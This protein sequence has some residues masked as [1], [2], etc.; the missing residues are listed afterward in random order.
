MREDL[1][2]IVDALAA[3]LGRG[4]AIDD[5]NLGLLAHSAHIDEVDAVRRQSILGRQVS[6]AAR[7]WALSCGIAEA[8]APV[9][10]PANPAISCAARVCAPIRCRDRLLGFLFVID[11]DESTT[12]E[13]IRRCEESARQA[14]EVIYESRFMRHREWRRERELL[15]N[16]LDEDAEVRERAASALTDEGFFGSEQIVVAVVSAIAD[17]GPPA[18]DRLVLPLAAT[19]DRVRRALPPHSAI[20]AV[21]PRHAALVVEAPGLHRVCGGVEELAVWLRDMADHE[22]DGVGH[23]VVG[24]GDAVDG[25]VSAWESYEQANR[26]RTVAA[27][28]PRF[29]RALTWQNAGPYRMLVSV[30]VGAVEGACDPRIWPLLGH[31]ELVKT[32]EVYL[33]LAGDVK[34]TSD[35]LTLH[36]ASLYYRLQKIEQISGVSLKSGEDR[37]ALH[38]GLKLL[39]LADVL[40]AGPRGGTA[41]RPGRRR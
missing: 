17:D 28:V 29:D 7:Q 16:L 21:R 9:R 14:G 41:P 36:R 24:C 25:L 30:P 11:A 32:L 33:D 20:G 38:V 34:A 12:D 22:L 4:V 31:E 18:A 3:E 2:N 1:Q 15:R 27:R 10:V 39:R 6:E 26:S 23:A 35:A 8:V 13:Q 37:L 5:R 19:L 40:G